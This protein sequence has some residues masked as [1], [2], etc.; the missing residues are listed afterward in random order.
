MPSS[1][2][3]DSASLSII[4]FYKYHP[5]SSAQTVMEPY[6]AAM[7][8]LCQS[9]HL[10]GRILLGLS[11]REGING[12]L[13][14]TQENVRAFTFALLGAQNCASLEEATQEL[15]Q[16]FFQA[17]Q[18]FSRVAGVPP[19]T[20]DS[21]EDFKWS[22]TTRKDLFPDLV[23]KLVK[24]I[25]N[26]GGVLAS[27][28]LEET[29]QGY[30]TPQQWHD[31]MTDLN[32]ENTVL[33]DCRNTK[34]CAIGHFPN[35][36]DPHTTT[37]SQFP[38]WAETHAPQLKEKRV[39]M[40]CTGGIR[41]EKAS[42][43]LRRQGVRQVQH[44]KGGIHK[45]LEHYGKD[46]MWKGKNFVFDGRGAASAE[47]TQFG[48]DGSVGV[49]SS[50]ETVAQD[51]ADVVGR[52]MYC[53]SPYDTF[54][55]HCVCTV[56][57][58][59][60][61]VCGSCQQGVVEFHCFGHFHLRACYFTNLTHFSNT[62]LER[63]LEELQ[64]HLEKIAVGKQYKQKRKTLHK[65]CDEIRAQLA[66]G[67]E[68]HKVS[69]TCRNCGLSECDGACW[70]F[71]GLKR[72]ELLE[73]QSALGSTEDG[74]RV[75]RPNAGQRVSKQLQRQRAIE[76]IEKLQLSQPPSRHLRL[77]VRVPPPCTRVL[78]TL[79]KGKWCGRP[80]IE[81][82]QT[83]FAELAKPQVFQDMLNGGL[84]RLNDD[85]LTIET[86]YTKLKNMDVIS[87][88]VHWHEPPIQTPGIICVEKVFLLKVGINSDAFVY[89]CDKPSSVPV[90]PAGPYLS[91]TLTMMVEAQE[92]LETR[93]LIPCHR[94]DRV[95]SG[96]TICCTDVKIARVIQGKIDEGNVR[97]IYVAQVKGRFPHS[98]DEATVFTDIDSF[99]KWSWKDD[100]RCVEVDAPIETIDAGNGIRTVSSKG[101]SSRSRFQ[102]LAYNST[103]DSSLI[104]CAPLTGRGHQLR[105]HLQWLGFPIDGDVSYGGRRWDSDC[106]D[107]AVQL[108]VEVI[109]NEEPFDRTVDSI[110]RDVVTAARSAC[111]CC[112]NAAEGVVSSFTQAQLLNGSGIC[113]HALRYEI[114]FPK[115]K[116]KA[117]EGS[118]ESVTVL[119]MEVGLPKWALE[120][121]NIKIDW[122]QEYDNSTSAR[123]QL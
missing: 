122:L 3:A 71:H 114:P 113:L 93:S 55:P 121:G 34:E 68:N 111:L 116:R 66:A 18:Q 77:G 1:A 57:R 42:A 96:L 91:N 70:G 88:V 53:S 29:S 36:V 14:G 2:S 72:K 26:T 28:P 5:F 59:P 52:C 20:M 43:Y 60:T 98:Q 104:A 85:P 105:V 119:N 51:D 8:S 95:T 81:V 61:L 69:N 15:L 65:Q 17:S 38:Q 107:T 115:R 83:E 110:S 40:Y 30:L 58:E 13:A 16:N 92:Q 78:Q 86:V 117:S 75:A 48:K 25:I 22:S 101:K 73:K 90:H 23:V 49:D 80:A 9:L 32:P 33:I 24:E 97:K 35:A 108:M 45:Y 6:R 44:L 94:I 21:P 103:I 46:G 56:C 7:E 74:T 62:E 87:R 120:Y 50:G 79:V 54:H 10:K 37:F 109:S 27:I 19:L 39:L 64:Q 11:E 31:A 118:C 106:F 41:C 63:Q 67:N 47:E 102:V 76:E 123:R 82:L 12:T 100:L 99:A 84:L 112:K 4:L 89:V